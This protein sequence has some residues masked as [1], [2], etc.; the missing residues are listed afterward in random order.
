MR[1]RVRTRLASG[2]A[3]GAAPAAAAPGHA[4]A[5]LFTS[6]RVVFLSD[7]DRVRPALLFHS[8][9]VTQKRR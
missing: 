6:G 2:A 4:E 1:L 3:G 7:L 5:A 8:D 9:N